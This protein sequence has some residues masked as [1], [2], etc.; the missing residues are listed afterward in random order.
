[1]VATNEK[2]ADPGLSSGP[3]WDVPSAAY[4]SMT[5]F[6]STTWPSTVNLAK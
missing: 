2:T 5:F 3:A 6:V 4:S 1:M